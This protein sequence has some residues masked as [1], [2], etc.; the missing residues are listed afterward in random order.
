MKTLPS[1]AFALTL[2]AASLPLSSPLQAGTAVQRC[3]SADGGVVYTD[4]ACAALGASSRP[5]PSDLLNR[6][7][8]EDAN[9]APMPALR[10]V[11]G[12]TR[13]G[14]ARR[15][16]TAGCARTPT[17]LSMDLR[18]SLAIADVNRLAESHH[19]VGM[20]QAQSQPIMQR[21]ERLSLQPLADVHYFDAQ[22]GPGGMQLAD[23]GH[24]LAAS[25]VIQLTFEGQRPALDL[26]VE[27]YAG[28]Y[29]VKF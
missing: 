22:S 20:S 9:T 16:P 2:L 7:A 3:Q 11:A 29:F 18:A 23:A 12:P 27:R 17:Q 26:G 21:L 19:W 6:I 1:A 13:N 5:L 15:S 14:L 10:A 24:V 8:R 28:C 25:D 4:Q